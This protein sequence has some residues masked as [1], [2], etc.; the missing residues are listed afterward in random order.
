M[1]LYSSL[2]GYLNLAERHITPKF[3]VLAD[4]IGVLGDSCK[5]SPARF[6]QVKLLGPE[7]T[8]Q[9]TPQVPPEL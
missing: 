1:I 9:L 4:A 2:V 3:L 6:G 8:P 5:T 7:K